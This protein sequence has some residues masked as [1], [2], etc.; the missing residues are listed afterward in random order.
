MAVNENKQTSQ[1]KYF[2]AKSAEDTATIL[3]ERS[4]QWFQTL[5]NNGYLNKLRTM[6]LAYHG[7]YYDDGIGEDSHQISFG[8]EQGELVQLAVN[9]LRNLGEYMVTMIT[10]TRP[11]LDA[12]ATNSDYK[13]LVQTRLANGL[14]E[15]YL[16]D[17]KLEEYLKDACKFAVAMASGYV[18]LEWNATRGDVYDVDPETGEEYREGDLEFSNLS[19]F[20]VMFDTNRDDRNHDWV[21]TR[22]KK[23]RFDLA[24]KYPELADKILSVATVDQ[25][26]NRGSLSFGYD[27]TDLIYVYEFY[28]RRCEAL[29]EGRYMLYLDGD[30]IL[31][32]SRMPYRELPVYG[33]APAYYLGTPFAYTPLFDLLPIQDA[34]N[35]LASTILTN[36]TTFGVQS[37]VVP[38]NANVSV[39]QLE[40]GMNILEVDERNGQI[41]PLQLTATPAEIFNFLATLEKQMETISGVNAVARG[42]P[43]PNLRSGNALALIQ[44]QT[45]QFLSGL[46][47]SYVRLLEDV[48]TGIIN[49]LKDHATVPRIIAIT[50]KNNKPYVK[51]FKGQDLVDI[52]RVTVK[53]GNPLSRTTAGRVEMAEQLLQMG[54]IK[55]AEDYLSVIDTGSLDVLTE[56]TQSHLY[57]A[58]DENERLVS[59]K[60][61]RALLTD[62]HLMH[63]EEHQSI[64]SDSDLR[65]DEELVN[66]VL[67]HIQEHFDI[68]SD[69]NVANILVALGQQPIAPPQAPPPPE[70]QGGEPVPANAMDVNSAVADVQGGEPVS[71]A[72][73]QQ[74]VEAPNINL[75]QVDPS[76]LPNPELQEQALGNVRGMGEQ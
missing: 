73:S 28:H 32:D 59:G 34:F 16:R 10:S 52:S 9:H 31:L 49:I 53:V 30:I 26:L 18:K 58:K 41:R 12:M 67:N 54:L 47:Q 29:P 24:A 64:L 60:T 2:A 36:Q 57:L 13:S 63:I 3:V 56:D 33:M 71:T 19:P 72:L 25:F 48:G 44:A 51:E 68:L 7:S 38:P 20:D 65:E 40:S 76:L 66:R 42:N 61:V 22:S 6:W 15:Y 23:K 35:S 55:K 4:N 43:D 74:G 27:E 75:P 37:I 5:E 70:G 14:L 45:L 1:E 8:G 46:Q 50:G 21:I 17:K 39:S 11:S 62:K 69:P